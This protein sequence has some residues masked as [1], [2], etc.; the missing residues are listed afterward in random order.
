M[1]APNQNPIAN[2][3][4]QQQQ[5]P[6][7]LLSASDLRK[8]LSNSADASNVLA[9]TL[10]LTLQKNATACQNALTVEKYSAFYGKFCASASSL[11]SNLTTNFVPRFT[12]AG[13]KVMGACIK[14]GYTTYDKLYNILTK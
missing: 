7:Q 3:G 14:V 6:K 4:E 8:E 11:G 9:T 2:K 10:M 13:T 1:A 5:Q 12:D